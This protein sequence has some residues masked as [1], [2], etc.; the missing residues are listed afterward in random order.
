[1]IPRVSTDAADIIGRFADSLETAPRRLA[2]EAGQGR[3]H[4]GWFCTYTPLELIHAAGF[5]PVRLGGMGAAVEQADLLTPTFLCPFLRQAVARALEGG[6]DF[7]WGLVQGYTCDAACGAAAVWEENFPG[8]LFHSLPLPYN[9][10]P[11][12]REFCR[13]AM[14]ELLDKLI[15]AGGV[16]SDEHLE[17]SL[18]LYGRLRR[19]LDGL[20]N[21]R[22]RLENGLDASEVLAITNA[23]YT[24]PPE[25]AV[26]LL[27]ELL[28][29]PPAPGPKK[30]GGVPVL[31][32]GSVIEDGLVLDLLEDCGGT[33]A[34]DDL[35]SGSRGLYPLDGEGEAPMDRLVDRLMKRAPCPA[36]C[37]AEDRAAYLAGLIEASGARGAVFILQ[38]FCTPHLADLPALTAALKGMGLPSLLIELEET[39]LSEGQLR[40][41]FESFFEMLGGR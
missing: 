35:C 19:L 40:T 26:A 6:Y 34:A 1:M 13:A 9:D 4:I 2:I 8:R 25:N 16:Y 23:V 41:R 5:T 7:L 39:G 29:L 3:R 38:K 18:G 24:L 17:E 10:S 32:S 21:P 37:R 12:S 28:P 20:Q 22:A 33:V 14:Y 36:R 11:A 15:A 30:D 27:E 31:V